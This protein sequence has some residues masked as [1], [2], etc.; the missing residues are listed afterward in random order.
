[1]ILVDANILLYATIKESMLHDA[2]RRWLEGQLQGNARV[3]LPWASLLAFVRIAT[4]SRVSRTP[5][6]IR[7]AWEQVEAWLAQEPAWIPAPTDRH[8]AVMSQLLRTRGLQSD[9]VP[10]CHLAAI[11]MQHGLTL[12]SCDAGFARFTGLRW[13]NPVAR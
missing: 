4:H 8:A 3:G 13:V 6:P 12:M 9:D 7:D 10:D 2:A 1:M 11:A 5:L